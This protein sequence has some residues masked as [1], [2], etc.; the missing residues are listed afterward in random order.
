MSNSIT[1]L[2]G[3]SLL[4]ICR[5]ASV[6]MPKALFMPPAARRRTQMGAGMAAAAVTLNNM[7]FTCTLVNAQGALV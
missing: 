5:A 1:V 2:V 3:P 7:P 6:A 4:I